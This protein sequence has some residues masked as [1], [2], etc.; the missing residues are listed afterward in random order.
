M[1]MLWN[2][3]DFGVTNRM[4][5]SVSQQDGCFLLY[6]GLVFGVWWVVGGGGGGRGW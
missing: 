4:M 6:S 1:M 3:S 2:C 5:F